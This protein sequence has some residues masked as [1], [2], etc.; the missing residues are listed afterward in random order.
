MVDGV[1]GADGERADLDLL[2]LGE[3][4]DRAEAA[5][6]EEPPAP[7]RHDVL[8]RPD[9]PERGDM[10]MVVVHVGD[11][12]GVELVGERFRRWR[13]AEDVAEPSPQ[14]RVREQADARCLDENRAMSDPGDAQP[15][16]FWHDSE[17]LNA[18]DHVSSFSSSR[19]CDA[20][21]CRSW[22]I[23]CTAPETAVIAAVTS[24]PELLR[25]SRILSTFVF[26]SSVS[27]CSSCFAFSTVSVGGLPSESRSSRSCLFAS[28]TPSAASWSV[29][30][31]RSPFATFS[32]AAATLFCQSVSAL[33]IPSAQSS[34]CD[35]VSLL[36]PQPAAAM[37]SAIVA[38]TAASP[39]T[40]MPVPPVACSPGTRAPSGAAAPQRQR[41][42]RRRESA[43]GRSAGH[44]SAPP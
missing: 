38:A 16:S 14:Q 32:P 42:R 44:R 31:E 22:P 2:A 19:S 3:L 15:L 6:L 37:A 1:R 23:A 8:P 12:D 10:Q 28:A 40:L 35:C 39:E 20:V 30:F 13:N 7:G 29:D 26:R 25:A 34:V 27:C 11:Q 9:E 4:D 21:L 17:L 5:G 43:A 24:L 41:T 36:E 18:F 33:H